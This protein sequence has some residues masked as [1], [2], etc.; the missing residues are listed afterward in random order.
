VVPRVWLVNRPACSLVS[1]RA[2]SLRTLLAPAVRVTIEGLAGK[3]GDSLPH[4]IKFAQAGEVLCGSRGDT[5]KKPATL[6]VQS[7]AEYARV[8]GSLNSAHTGRGPPVVECRP[9]WK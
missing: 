8:L 7:C 5:P 6:L 4:L 9:S 2:L 1:A 3:E